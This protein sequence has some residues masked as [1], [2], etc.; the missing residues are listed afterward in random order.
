MVHYQRSRASILVAKSSVSLSGD[1][2]RVWAGP[3]VQEGEEQGARVLF[4]GLWG[5]GRLEA[6]VRDGVFSCMVLSIGLGLLIVG[7]G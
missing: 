5:V 2:V 6:H 7:C 3:V 4:V 1:R